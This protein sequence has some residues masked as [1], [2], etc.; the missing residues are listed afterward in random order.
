MGPELGHPRNGDPPAT[1]S[2]QNCTV[3]AGIG[4]AVRRQADH[5]G[6][7]KWRICH[8]PIFR[9][10]HWLPEL[11]AIHLFRKSV[12][13]KMISPGLNSS[14]P[15]RFYELGAIKFQEL[16]SDLLEQDPRYFNSEVYGRNGQ[17]QRGVDIIAMLAAGGGLDVGSCK[18]WEVETTA[19]KIHEAT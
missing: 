11:T 10:S 18:C 2:R 7:P 17:A 5:H 15:P 1:L 6:R 19:A 16:C 14:L 4:G 8:F 12:R 3:G 9:R 13:T